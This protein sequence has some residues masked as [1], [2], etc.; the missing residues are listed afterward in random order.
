V[1]DGQLSACVARP[2]QL[3]HQQ[4]KAAGRTPRLHQRLEGTVLAGAAQ[5]AHAQHADGRSHQ[6]VE[7]PVFHK[8]VHMLQ[9]KQQ[10]RMLVVQPQLLRHLLKG[11]A[12]GNQL[13]SAENQQRDLRSGRT[14]IQNIDG[15]MGLFL[16]EQVAPQQGG[17]IADSP[18]VMVMAIT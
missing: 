15:F 7:P 18:P 14:G 5:N 6:L 11:Q 17:I 16:P 9:Q 3:A 13:A 8:V 12:S 1:G 2:L 10:M 4:I